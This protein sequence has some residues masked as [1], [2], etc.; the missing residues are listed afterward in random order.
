VSGV[1][2]GA[3]TVAAAG[4][5]RGAPVAC[6][7][8]QPAALA[9][10]VCFPHAGGGPM[11]FRGWTKGLAPDVEVWNVTLPGRAGRAAE[12]FAG[13][14]GPL[15]EEFAIA[16]ADRVPEPCALFGHSLGAAIA[17]EV[18]RALTRLGAPP[19]HLFV[20]ARDA[21]DTPDTQYEVPATDDE[22]LDEVD[23]AYGGVPDAVRG[24]EELLRHFL[25]IL[26][27]DLELAVSYEFA[28]GRPLTCGVSALAGS[29]DPTVTRSGL[30]AWG[31][32]TAG[33]F[34]LLE[35]PGGHFY[36]DGCEPAVLET[37]HRR[38]IR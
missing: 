18:A 34:E 13:E 12:P 30:E 15:V 14:W 4:A 27:A 25:P 10:L 8:P 35:L 24:S 36:L 22:L 23:R 26:R 37:I 33:G 1:P 3:P 28:P 29:G 6:R 2:Q 16:I 19:A 11:V 9:R 21:P 32:H 31:P 20:S 7:S 5:R 17:F 38:L